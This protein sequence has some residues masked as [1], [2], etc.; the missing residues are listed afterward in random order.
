MKKISLHFAYIKFIQKNRFHDIITSS[1]S[2][3]ITKRISNN[4]SEYSRE[5]YNYI[6]KL[7][8][9]IGQSTDLPYHHLSTLCNIVANTFD[10]FAEID[11]VTKVTKSIFLNN[12][13]F[14][15]CSLIYFN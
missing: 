10:I 3:K 14:V 11:D 12:S 9:Y 13:M 6:R 4:T 7:S 1:V 8:H 15:T 5:D 2:A